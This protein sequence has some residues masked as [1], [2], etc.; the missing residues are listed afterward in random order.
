VLAQVVQITHGRSPSVFYEEGGAAAG[1]MSDQSFRLNWV[2]VGALVLLHAGAMAALFLFTWPALWT[3]LALL[4]ISGGWGI[5]MGYHRLLTHRGYETPR[6]LECLLTICGTLALQGGPLFWVATHRLHHQNADKNGDPH[7]P[8][9][10]WWWSHAGW[11]VRGDTMRDAAL[12]P[13][14]PDLRRDP[15]HC[16]LEKWHVAPLLVLSG[17]LG[18]WGAVRGGAVLA[19]SL[20]SWGIFLRTTVELHGTWLVNSAAHTW[21]NRRFQTRD[22]STN[23][24]WVALLTFGE[25]WHN[26]HHA[27]PR[28]VRHG[29]AWYELDINWLCIRAL[30]RVGLAKKL[31]LGS[32][33]CGPHVQPL[34]LD[35]P[36]SSNR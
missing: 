15:F 19:G 8:R 35:P 2:T 26:N 12:A 1:T 36:V 31:C 16:W 20:V 6:W 5:G 11:L 9:D 13:Y 17:V 28:C 14:V 29:L 22:D 34:V 33:V 4:W 10:G 30:H 21:G 7:S 27:D 25:G 24:W 3:A 23:N 32:A 18:V